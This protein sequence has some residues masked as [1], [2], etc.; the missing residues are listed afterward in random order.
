MMQHP[1]TRTLLM[2]IYKKYKI[3]DEKGVPFVIL[4]NLAKIQRLKLKLI[5]K[6]VIPISIFISD[7]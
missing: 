2:N 5:I 1:G 4:H 3:A 7:H 6:S